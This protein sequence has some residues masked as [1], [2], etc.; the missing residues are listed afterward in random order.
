VSRGSAQAFALVQ[1]LARRR[2][3][4]LLNGDDVRAVLR[5]PAFRPGALAQ[6]DG[7]PLRIERRGHLR[8]DY[9]VHDESTGEE[10]ARLRREGRRRL[11]ELGG[12][13]GV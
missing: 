8:A 2:E 13:A 3:W 1:P 9:V 12:R 11:L 4:L 6:A 10:V 7:R 5:I